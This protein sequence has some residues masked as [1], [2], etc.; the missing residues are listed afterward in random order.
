MTNT[1]YRADIRL[2]I[3][4]G[5]TKIEIV[6]LDRTGIERFRKRVPTPQ[7]DYAGTVRAIAGLVADARAE[8][9]QLCAKPT[10]GVGIPGTISPATGLVK[11]ANSVCLIGHPLDR[12][13]EAAVNIPVRLGNDANCFALSEASDGAAKDYQIVFGAILGTGT[14]SGLVIDKKVV[15]GP[16]AITGEWGHIRLPW[17]TPEE[18]PGPDCYCGLK[19]CVEAF[20]SGPGLAADFKR[21]NGFTCTSE[22]IAE[23]KDEKTKAA[24]DR[25][26]DRL[27]RAFST[28]IN[29]IDPSV[30]VVGGGLSKIPRL[31]TDVAPLLPKYTFSDTVVTP[32]VPAKYGDSSGVR[33]AAWLWP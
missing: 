23:Q 7:G 21:V 1:T 8:T 32:I 9:A 26:I 13:I 2:G 10:L 16:N 22:E 11:G 3:D 12:D 31:Y 25:Y 30:I 24:M 5:G 19:G 27:A 6:A 17:P 29:I 28:I 14:G 33:G 20:L 18:T 4:L 15:S